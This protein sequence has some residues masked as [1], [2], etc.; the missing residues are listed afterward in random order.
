MYKPIYYYLFIC[1][2]INRAGVIHYI[3]YWTFICHIMWFLPF[4]LLIRFVFIQFLHK[5]ISRVGSYC[6]PNSPYCNQYFLI[7][8]KTYVRLQ[9][10]MIFDQTNWQRKRMTVLTFTK[11]LIVRNYHSYL[12]ARWRYILVSE[13]RR[14]LYY[15]KLEQ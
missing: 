11:H 4:P 8:Q 7:L 13:V 10:K 2:S 3:C 6:R 9:L 5:Q 1:Y 15:T 12:F 14:V